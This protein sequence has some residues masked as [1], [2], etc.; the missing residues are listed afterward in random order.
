[1]PAAK[2]AA[3]SPPHAHCGTCTHT[4]PFYFRVSRISLY[5]FSVAPLPLS[6]PP[7]ITLSLHLSSAN[8]YHLFLDGNDP[9]R[10][11]T[12]LQSNIPRFKAPGSLSQ[13]GTIE[14]PYALALVHLSSPFFLLSVCPLS[15]RKLSCSSF[16]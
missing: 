5:G 12:I 15:Y 3:L 13:Q 6:G 16:L 10:A 4:H 1:M 8:L 2:L 11:D 9:V 7:S 14:V